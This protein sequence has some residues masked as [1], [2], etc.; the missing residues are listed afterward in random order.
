MRVQTETTRL[1]VCAEP[2]INIQVDVA[3]PAVGWVGVEVT[4]PGH[5]AVMLE[6]QI[7]HEEDLKKDGSSSLKLGSG[8]WVIS[9]TPDTTDRPFETSLVKV[10]RINLLPSRPTIS[11]VN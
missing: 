8:S 2:S 9:Y 11:V 10:S 1:F 5:L 7:Q 4:E 3:A 6:G